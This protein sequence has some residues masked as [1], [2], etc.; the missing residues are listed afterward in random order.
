MTCV[1]S[2]SYPRVCGYV[3]T[4][5]DD[6]LYENLINSGSSQFYTASE[7]QKTRGRNKPLRWMVVG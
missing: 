5:T 1:H 2:L 4:D 7:C 3:R 6:R